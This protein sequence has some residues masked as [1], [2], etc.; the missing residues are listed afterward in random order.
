MLCLGLLHADSA[1]MCRCALTLTNLWGRAHVYHQF[2]PFRLQE[3]LPHVLLRMVRSGHF[4]PAAN[5]VIPTQ[6]RGMVRRRALSCWKMLTDPQSCVMSDVDAVFFED[7]RDRYFHD[8]IGQSVHA[9]EL[10][11]VQPDPEPAPICCEALQPCA[12]AP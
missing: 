8:A 10:G 11:E 3:E 12:A 9:F 5:W 4:Y 2:H 1:F 7:C 6:G